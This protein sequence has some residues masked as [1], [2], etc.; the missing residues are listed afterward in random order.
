[1]DFKLCKLQP[2]H[3]PCLLFHFFYRTK[4]IIYSPKF[5]KNLIHFKAFFCFSRLCTCLIPCNL[6]I[7]KSKFLGMENCSYTHIFKHSAT[8]RTF[9]SILIPLTFY[10]SFAVNKS[11]RQTGIKRLLRK[12][13]RK[14]SVLRRKK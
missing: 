14:G 10:T 11:F 1:M 6:F 7:H 12:G 9:L 8:V 2:L 4:T 3:A 13:E 5:I